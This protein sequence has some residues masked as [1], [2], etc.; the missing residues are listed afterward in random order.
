[1][2]TRDSF[3]GG[4]AAGLEADHPPPSSVEAKNTWSYTSTPSWR[5]AQLKKKHGDY[6]TYLLIEKPEEE[7]LHSGSTCV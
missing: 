4:K 2:G 3:P 1:M 5:G 7:P 6:F